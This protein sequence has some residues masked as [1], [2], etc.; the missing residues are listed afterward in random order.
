MDFTG[1][2]LFLILAI[3]K[4]RSSGRDEI[5]RLSRYITYELEKERKRERGETLSPYKPINPIG[6]ISAKG[7]AR[8]TMKSRV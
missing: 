6:R 4:L 2:Y 1:A 3:C 5:A 8:C 7:P